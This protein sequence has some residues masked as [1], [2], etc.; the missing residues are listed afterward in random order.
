VKAVETEIDLDG[1]LPIEVL[2]T[3]DGQEDELAAYG[4]LR[5]SFG[6]ASVEVGG[7]YS[8][9]QKG[10]AG[11]ADR[12]D[13]ALSAFTG[14][15]VP[16]GR[17]FE[18][19]GSLGT[20]LRFS[21]LSERFFAG[22]TARGGVI[23]NPQ[24]D[25]ERSLNAD[26]ALR[27]YGKRLFVAGSVFRNQID[28]YIEPDLLTYV[29]LTSGRIEGLELEGSYQATQSWHLSWSAHRLRDRD[30]GG[31]A[32]ADVPVDNLR[33][34]SHHRLGAWTF[35]GDLDL[36]AAKDDPGSGETT[37]GS[38]QLLSAAVTRRFDD[39][40]ALTVSCSNLL[41]EEYRRSADDKAPLAAGRSFG[42]AV[43]LGAR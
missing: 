8:W 43:R 30:D 38:A 3:L 11:T 31:A 10:N 29:N 34:S 36:R 23:G 33:L 1:D 17:G 24:L 2:N 6:K 32:L 27:W 26:L 7:R 35:E 40:W 4:S 16:L 42:V 41:D 39:R 9:L 19:A 22:T 21:S 25:P 18:L 15:T 28:D 20:G 37:I 13:S 5:R 12:T 14:V